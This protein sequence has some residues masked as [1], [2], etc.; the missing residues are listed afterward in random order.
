MDSEKAPSSPARFV[1]AHGVSI[2]SRYRKQDEILLMTKVVSDLAPEQRG[3]IKSILCDSK[4]GNSFSV[5]IQPGSDDPT[6]T[7]P[8]AAALSR[9]LI[10][11][12][13]GHGDLLV[14]NTAEIEPTWD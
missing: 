3:L 4:V 5:E 13:G 2:A 7:R 6:H 10:K 8:L 12:R 14:G 9:L 1:V 11:H